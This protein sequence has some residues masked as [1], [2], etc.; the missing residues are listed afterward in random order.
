M[1]VR[2]RRKLDSETLYLPAMKRLILA[3]AILLVPS[4]VPRMRSSG[5]E[6]WFVPRVP[7]P[8]RFALDMQIRP[9]PVA[10]W[11]FG[12]PFVCYTQLGG[13][14]RT[15]E[16]SLL[17]WP[18]MHQPP[19]GNRASLAALFGDLALAAGIGIV[20]AVGRYRLGAKPS[21]SEPRELPRDSEDNAYRAPAS[22]G[23]G[24]A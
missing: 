2:I 9:A 8:E 6:R 10:T 17:F 22:E 20:F 5:A 7:D 18:S 15:K 12:Y 16:G 19:L 3:T 1:T 23:D 24:G 21:R 13:E 14:F 11:A 4:A